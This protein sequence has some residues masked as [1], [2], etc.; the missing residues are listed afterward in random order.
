VDKKVSISVILPCFNE[1]KNIRKNIGE[2]YGYLERNYQDFEIIA[3]N[4]G[5]S[6]NTLALLRET[7]KEHPHIPLRIINKKQ[8]VG[9]G[10]AVRTGILRS[11]GEIAMFMDADLAIPIQELKKFLAAI[12]EGNDVVIASR[13]VGKIKVL[14]PV[15]WYRSIMEKVFRLLRMIITNNFDVQDTQCG[16][17]I[18]TRSAAQTIFSRTTVNGWSFDVEVIFLAEKMGLKI[19]ELP[20]TLQNPQ[21]SHIRIVRDS[22]NMFFDLIRI[23]LNDWQGKYKLS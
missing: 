4:D 13:F 6:D 1:A 14:K 15:L 2:I 20:I 21:E 5:S 7:K 3:V 12:K 16:F 11:R 19:K 9:K 17:K 22:L 23:R 18:F 8:N 10:G